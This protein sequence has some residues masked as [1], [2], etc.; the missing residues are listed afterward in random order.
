VHRQLTLSTKTKIKTVLKTYTEQEIME[1][2]D[3]YDTVLKG[4][5]YYWSHYW[6]LKDFL[7]RGL[8]KFLSE[9]KPLTNFLKDKND[10]Y[11]KPKPEEHRYNAGPKLKKI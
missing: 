8:D 7:Q 5:D 4:D 11:K 9:A 6:T 1:A 3:N 10:G 2:I